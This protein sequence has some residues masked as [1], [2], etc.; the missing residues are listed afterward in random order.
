MKGPE[1]RLVKRIREQIQEKYPEAYVRKIH[2]NAFQNI[3]ISD[4]LGSIDG[5][6]I[7][8]EVKVPGRESTA[9]PAQL[10]EI[11]KVKKSGGAA[12]VVVSFA[13]AD[14]II[15]DALSARDRRYA[16]SSGR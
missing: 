4:L 6:F 15:S 14:K 1:S 12:G 9:T 3:G 7:A 11:S 10:L 2:G 16:R 5:L 13:Q 8:L